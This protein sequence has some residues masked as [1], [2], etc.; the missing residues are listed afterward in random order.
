MKEWPPGWQS[1]CALSYS[2]IFWGTELEWSDS[3]R[4]CEN[5][6]FW[7]KLRVGVCYFYLQCGLASKHK[8]KWAEVQG[9]SLTSSLPTAAISYLAH[10]HVWCQLRTKVKLQ[11]LLLFLH[12]GS[13]T[14]QGHADN[15]VK[16]WD[17]AFVKCFWKGLWNSSAFSLLSPPQGSLKPC[18]QDADPHT[19]TWS[20]AILEPEGD[21]GALSPRGAPPLLLQS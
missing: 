18:R 17:K 3:Q 21:G 11:T 15:A 16:H 7:I 10:E 8:L 4:L 9:I 5:A 6:I 19:E 20:A 14:I 2:N 1:M 12:E 13:V